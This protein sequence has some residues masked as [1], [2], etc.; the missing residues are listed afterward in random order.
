[1]KT[2]KKVKAWV[3]QKGGLFW[4]GYGDDWGK[5]YHATLFPIQSDALFAIG[6]NDLGNDA[7][8]V[9]VA[10]ELA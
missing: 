2:K 1:M 10:V 4:D 3:I 5:L 8:S 7:C 6:T 9:K